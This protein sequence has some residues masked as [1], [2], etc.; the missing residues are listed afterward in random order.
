MTLGF[1]L[2]STIRKKRNLPA[3]FLKHFRTLD[4]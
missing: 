4:W 2:K 3:T 1:S